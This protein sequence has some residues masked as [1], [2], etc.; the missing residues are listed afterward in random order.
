[1][2]KEWFFRTKATDTKNIY[3]VPSHFNNVVSAK[4]RC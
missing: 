3:I 2:F 4:M 1:M